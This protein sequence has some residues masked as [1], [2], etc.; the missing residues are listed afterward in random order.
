MASAKGSENLIPFQIRS[1]DEARQKGS[2]GGKK[3]GEARRKKRDAKQAIQM[4]LDMAAVEEL[5]AH[6]ER[7]GYDEADHTNMNALTAAMFVQAMKGDVTA[8]KAL[9]EYGGFNPDQELK[10][11]RNKVEIES[12]EQEMQLQKEAAAKAATPD[13]GLIGDF[14]EVIQQANKLPKRKEDK[15]DESG[16]G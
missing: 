2:N 9:M 1:T 11:K 15:K 14:M 5:D 6:L 12:K 7:F 16:E 4:L 10:D 13:A 3:S 8:Y